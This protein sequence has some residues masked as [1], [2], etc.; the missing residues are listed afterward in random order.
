MKYLKLF[1]GFSKGTEFKVTKLELSPDKEGFV[2]ATIEWS[3]EKRIL[4]ME[5]YYFL[6]YIQKEN[7][8]LKAYISGL[9]GESS[10][11]ILGDLQEIG[12]SLKP[13]M[14]KYV[15][16]KMT[17]E[18]F[19]K[20][21][22]DPSQVSDADVKGIFDDEDGDVGLLEEGWKSWVA[23]ALLFLTSCD[24]VTI[25]DKTGKELPVH[26]VDEKY[27]TTGTIIELTK[28]PM[29]NATQYEITI[30]DDITGNN[31]YIEKHAMNPFPDDE[32]PANWWMSN[33]KEGSRVKIV[34]RDD[35][36]VYLLDKK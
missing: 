27:T 31:I 11:M 13:I 25:K 14:Q 30:K 18:E 20:L 17:M 32:T 36:K 9:K 5:D 35:C 34:C 2:E 33:L 1:E 26:Y 4:E 15:D 3:T 28:M 19:E 24:S 8:N 6:A 12:V 23:G 7:E 22:W 16:E 29:K 10:E 21:N